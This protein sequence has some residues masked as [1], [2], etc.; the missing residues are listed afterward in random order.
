[1]ET[2][3]IELAY[4]Q[5]LLDEEV[6]RVLCQHFEWHMLEEC[7]DLFDLDISNIKRPV[8]ILPNLIMQKSDEHLSAEKAERF[9]AV[10][11]EFTPVQ[12]LQITM[13]AWHPA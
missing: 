4:I 7:S 8:D 6:V 10:W 3:E 5:E 2:L 13:K 1:M 12:Q 11:Q 9:K